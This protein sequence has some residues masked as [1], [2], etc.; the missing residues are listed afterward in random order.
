MRRQVKAMIVVL[1]LG[2]FVVAFL[3]APVIYQNNP[4]QD[5]GVVAKYESLS[6]YLFGVGISYGYPEFTA[7]HMVL[8]S[9]CGLPQT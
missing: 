6:C 8:M 3:C 4:Y 7:N 5:A 1:A 2:L 9:Y